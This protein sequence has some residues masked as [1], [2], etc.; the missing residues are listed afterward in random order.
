MLGKEEG[1]RDLLNEESKQ[2]ISFGI[3]NKFEKFPK[4]PIK[5]VFVQ[6]NPKAVVCKHREELFYLAYAICSKVI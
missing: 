2:F 5:M 3:L 4:V 6:S 1:F